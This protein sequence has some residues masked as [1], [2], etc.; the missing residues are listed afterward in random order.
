[1]AKEPFWKT[2]TLDEMSEA[3]W[4]SLCDGCGRCCLVKVDHP[5]GLGVLTTTVACQLLDISSCR[6]TRYSNRWAYVPDCI[7]MTPDRARTI[8]WLPMTCAYRL[9]ADGEEL[10][11]WHPLR[12]G[13]PGTV[14]LAQVS[15]RDMALSERD[16]PE[17]ELENY[18]LDW[19]DLHDD[20][21]G[22]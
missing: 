2:K 15:V 11:W 10:P 16:I 22:Q 21:E 13:N 19:V 3:E 5:N 17:E 7:E 14:H 8:D 18:L 6:C 12:T 20:A 4:E 9:I 1:M